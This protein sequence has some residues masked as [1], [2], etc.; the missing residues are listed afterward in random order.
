MRPSE[1]KVTF[2]RSRQPQ[3]YETAE[4]SVSL[5]LIAEED[6]EI[7]D[8][9]ETIAEALDTV[10]AHVYSRLGLTGKVAVNEPRPA[11]EEISE[12]EKAPRRGRPPKKAAEEKAAPAEEEKT[13]P[14]ITKDNTPAQSTEI[15]DGALTKAI[16]QAVKKL[17]DRGAPDGAKRI[18]DLIM[19]YV[20]NPPFSQSRI[21]MSKR[22]A[23]L[24]AL[25]ALT[26]E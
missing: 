11:K 6:E 1:I 12:A 17:V 8:L 26:E 10:Q 4:A 24:D 14:A 9:D 25:T 23:F 3:Q 7:R 15:S 13:T 2:R 21:E 18:T 5:T 22:Q 20:D 19:S 16:G